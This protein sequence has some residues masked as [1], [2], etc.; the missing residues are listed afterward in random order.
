MERC[1]KYHSRQT[2]G[3]VGA[4]INE[5][6]ASTGGASHIRAILLPGF[7]TG[8]GRP[9]PRRGC[10]FEYRRWRCRLLRSSTRRRHR[11]PTSAGTASREPPSL[12]GMCRRTG[13]GRQELTQMPDAVHVLVL[14]VFIVGADDVQVAGDAVFGADPK[15]LED[16]IPATGAGAAQGVER[17]V[18][19]RRQIGGGNSAVV[20][21]TGIV[22]SESVIDE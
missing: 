13:C 2:V 8:S 11:H 21:A 20:D 9:R 1:G 7:R 19:D 14:P 18:I 16:L 10:C 3:K 17:I 5:S 12:P 15:D 6:A 4:P 22:E